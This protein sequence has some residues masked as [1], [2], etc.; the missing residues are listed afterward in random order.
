[1]FGIKIQ[2]KKQS[3]TGGGYL[4]FD[5]LDI[6]TVI[7][8]SVITSRWHCRDLYYTTK[9]GRVIQEIRRKL[10]GEEMMSFAVNIHQT[11]DGRFEARGQGAA[12]ILG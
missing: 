12:K 4:S 1:M 11:I 8:E 9:D 3:K 6:L 10:S 7:S 5:L 2:D